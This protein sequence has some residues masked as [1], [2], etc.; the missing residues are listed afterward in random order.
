MEDIFLGMPSALTLTEELIL[1]GTKLGQVLMYDRE[2]QEFYGCFTEKG[3]EF[4]DNAVTVL[5]VHPH[6]SDSVLVGYQFG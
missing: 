2:T 4:T 1:I 3:K 6:R 5:E